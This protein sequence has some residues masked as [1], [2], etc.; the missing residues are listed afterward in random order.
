MMSATWSSFC[1]ETSPTASATP[2]SA[3]TLSSIETGIVAWVPVV[4][5]LTSS[6]SKIA[7]SVVAVD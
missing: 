4:E 1:G 2:G 6:F 7:A 5:P 3:R